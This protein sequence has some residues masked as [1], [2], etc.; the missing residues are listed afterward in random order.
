MRLD[1]LSCLRGMPGAP[2]QFRYR[3]RTAC[4]E[5]KNT[6]SYDAH[7]PHESTAAGYRRTD[8]TLSARRRSR[9]RSLQRRWNDRRCSAGI[10]VDCLLSELSPAA[11][12][13][14][15]RFVSKVPSAQFMAA[16]DA[17]LKRLTA[18]RA[19]LYTTTCRECGSSAELLYTVWAYRVLCPHCSHEFISRTCVVG[20]VVPSGNTR[21]SLSSSVLA[22]LNCCVS[23]DESAL[24][25]NLLRSQ[26]RAAVHGSA[27]KCI[28]RQTTISPSLLA[29]RGGR[30]GSVGTSRLRHFQT[31]STLV[32][33]DATVSTLFRS[34]TRVQ[35][36]PL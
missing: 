16:T 14:S 21:S 22:A 35:I 1:S 9:S 26:T 11:C 4:P 12:F 6:Y 20:T 5:E 29:Y 25:R 10:G 3:R 19:R 27:N 24:M 2:G 23:R 15:S 31:A 7:T 13:I 36:L 17:V 8:S 32:N 34:S 18:L 30:R 33:L 28:H